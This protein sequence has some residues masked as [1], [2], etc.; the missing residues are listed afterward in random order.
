MPRQRATPA[1]VPSPAHPTPAP[2]KIA[3]ALIALLL[4]GG[5][6]GLKVR[7]VLRYL[8]FSTEAEM[9]PLPL[10]LPAPEFSLPAGP[11]GAPVALSGL[12]GQHVLVHFWATWCPPCRDELRELEYLTRRL[13]GRL[14]V[15]AITVDDEWGEV[16][17]FFGDQ[18]PTF[19]ALWDRGRRA[20]SSYGTQKFPET[21]LI[22]PQGRIVAKFIGP[23][24]WNGAAALDYFGRVLGR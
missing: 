2:V 9:D 23:R 18:A 19:V 1:A 15:L 10:S 12:R 3:F 16:S 21:F 17:R 14:Q 7:E 22:D 13:R 6:V 5:A 20:A 11:G 24:D 8:E 4:L